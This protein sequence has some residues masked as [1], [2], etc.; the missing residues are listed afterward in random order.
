MI[1]QKLCPAFF[2]EYL[3]SIQ[4]P[5]S[6]QISFI[7]CYKVKQILISVIYTQQQIKHF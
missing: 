3:A 4:N 7:I 2:L 6:L 1:S 5:I